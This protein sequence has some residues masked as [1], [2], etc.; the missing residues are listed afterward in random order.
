MRF[1]ILTHHADRFRQ[2]IY[3]RGLNLE[4]KNLKSAEIVKS[5]ESAQAATATLYNTWQDIKVAE[6]TPQGRLSNFLSSTSTQKEML[7]IEKS[8]KRAR[9]RAAL[10]MY[11]KQGE[12][13]NSDYWINLMWA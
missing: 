3:L 2:E 13:K 6:V 7:S 11:F 10:K 8:K 1:L 12:R 5:V 4:L 9:E